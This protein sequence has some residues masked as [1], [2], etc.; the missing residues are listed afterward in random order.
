MKHIVPTLI[1]APDE[2][3]RAG[4]LGILVGAR[5]R[6]IAAKGGWEAAASSRKPLPVIV[7]LII[8]GTM[9]DAAIESRIETM[10]E[11][12]KVVVLADQ[13]DAMLVRGTMCA[14]AVAYLPRAVSAGVLL[15]TLDLVIEGEVVFPASVAQAVL[16][17]AQL[18]SKSDRA[19]RSASME[20]VAHL[21]SREIDVLKRLIQGDANKQ[22]SR[23]FNISETTVKVH[24]KAI[25]R[26]VRVRNRTQAAIWGLDHLSNLVG[27]PSALLQAS[28]R[29]VS[30]A[31]LAPSSVPEKA[32]DAKRNSYGMASRDL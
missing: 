12:T 13:C 30:E 26:K 23:Q 17:C 1:L 19:D 6:P 21:S 16:R 8:D 2:L 5:Y 28:D 15:Q 14:G 25:L 10:A 24:V 7:I 20:R 9:T 11:R 32:P 29:R 18:E 27:T 31:P 22:I 3:S 4:L